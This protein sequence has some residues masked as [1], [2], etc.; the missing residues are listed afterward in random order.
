MNK[1]IGRVLGF[2]TILSFVGVISA[3]MVQIM[4]RYLPYNAAWTEE[5]TRYFFIFTVCFGAP[6]GLL[7]GEYINVDIIVSRIPLFIRKYYEIGIFLLIFILNIVLIIEG[8]KFTQIGHSQMSATMGFPMSYIHVGFVILGVFLAY[9]SIVQIVR[10]LK[11]QYNFE[12]GYEE[13]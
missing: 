6:L 2:L 7:K 5:I 13:E 1:L 11:N 9:Y 12:Q 10:I 4:S 8:V 3:V